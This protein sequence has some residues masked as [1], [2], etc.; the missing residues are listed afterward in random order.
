MR[1]SCLRAASSFHLRSPRTIARSSST[2]CSV[3]PL[4]EQRGGQIE[5]GLMVGRIGLHAPSQLRDVARGLPALFD[6]ITADTAEAMSELLA[7]RR[8]CP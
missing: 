7:G 1:T 3:S 8:V 6:Q 2:A 5:A 4:R